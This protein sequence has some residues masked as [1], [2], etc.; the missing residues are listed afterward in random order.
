MKIMRLMSSD[1]SDE[2]LETLNDKSYMQY[3]RN[4]DETHTESSQFAYINSFYRYSSDPNS[5]ILG[6][7]DDGRLIGTSAI[8]FDKGTYCANV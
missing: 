7:F 2:Y 4:S 8:Y 6:I 1:I 3:S 5:I